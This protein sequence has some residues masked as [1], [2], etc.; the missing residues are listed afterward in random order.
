MASGLDL[1]DQPLAAQL[2][3]RAFFTATM[4]LTIA[5]FWA[6][7]YIGAVDLQLQDEAFMDTHRQGD[8]MRAFTI[9]TV[10]GVLGIPFVGYAMDTWGFRVTLAL[11][12]GLGVA[13]A[14]CTLIP[15][16]TVLGASFGVYALFRTFTF[17]F[18]F[19]FL[20]DSLGFRFFGVLAGASFFVAGVVGLLADPLM[21]YA[22]GACPTFPHDAAG[23]TAA[24]VAAEIA[25]CDHGNW[26]IVN[27]LKVG[28]L[29]LLFLF[30]LTGAVGRPG[31]GTP[32]TTK[33]ATV[34][35]GSTNH[36][37]GGGM[38]QRSRSAGKGPRYEMVH[39]QQG[40]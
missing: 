1:K 35:Y 7:F 25:A 2:T 37:A 22:H 33:Q 4:L 23:K 3:S 18:F 34:Q 20:A 14:A 24:E 32:T 28:T 15:D 12:V 26:D 36:A 31:P 8:Y 39:I 38:P 16:P 11:T 5:S 9:V 17:N 21:V 19:A 30:P 27:G 29:A 13:W 40:P 10:L 6:N